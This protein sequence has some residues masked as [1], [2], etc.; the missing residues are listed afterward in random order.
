MLVWKYLSII[1]T[2]GRYCDIERYKGYMNFRE[3]SDLNRDWRVRSR[4]EGERLQGVVQTM[5]TFISYL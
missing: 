4:L 5:L 2:I 3:R 1:I